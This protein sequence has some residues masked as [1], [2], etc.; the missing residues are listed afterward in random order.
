MSL[1]IVYNHNEKDQAGENAPRY[2]ETNYKKGIKLTYCMTDTWF[3]S[4]NNIKTVVKLGANQ[5]IQNKT[6]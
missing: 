1:R 2:A 5:D 6:R 4:R 3:G